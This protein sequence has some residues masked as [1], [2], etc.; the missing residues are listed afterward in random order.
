MLGRTVFL[1]ALLIAASAS[2]QAYR[3]P[4]TSFGAPDLQGVWTNESLT[5]LERKK[6]FTALVVSPEAAATYERQKV[7]KHEQGIAP[8]SPDAPAPTEGKVAQEAEQWYG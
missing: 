3:P 5:T 1:A 6:D 2:A 7:E 4:R 8:L